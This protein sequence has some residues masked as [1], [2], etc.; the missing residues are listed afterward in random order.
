MS[1]FLIQ[2]GPFCLYLALAFCVYSGLAAALGA[3]RD[4]PEWVRSAERGVLVVC[5]LL[6]CATES[7]QT[8]KNTAHRTGPLPYG[9]GS[10][11]S[12][13]NTLFD[14]IHSLYQGDAA[15]PLNPHARVTMFFVGDRFLLLCLKTFSQR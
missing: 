6:G 13:S 11:R 8:V 1:D 5:G 4:R 14:S 10:K 9:R 3:L 2:L 15:I 7:Y 12:F